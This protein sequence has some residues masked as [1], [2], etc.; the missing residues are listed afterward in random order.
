MAATLAAGPG[1]AL[2]HE[3][4][5]KHWKIWRGKVTGIDVTVPGQRRSREGVAI[6]RARHLDPRDVTIRQG[7]PITTP[8]R[9]LVDLATTLTA[10][11]LANVIHEA[12]YYGRFDENET[13]QAMARARGRDLTTLHAALQAHAHGSAGTRSANEDRFLAAWQG[14]QPL[15]NTKLHGIEVDLHWPGE[16]LAVEIDGPGHNRPRTRAEDAQR[17]AA[18]REA[19]VNVVRIPFGHG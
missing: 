19:G 7:I 18:L 13:E 16:N 3:A 9:T 15:V 17:D 14:P 12:A 10:H 6:H 4:A 5:A 2:S 11:Q 1:A 8:A